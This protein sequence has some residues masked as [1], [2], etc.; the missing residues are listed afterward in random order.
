MS[1][2]ESFPSWVY[3]F[4]IIP[5][6]YLFKRHFNY[7]KTVDQQQIRLNNHEKKIEKMCR[8]SDDLTK[9]VH[10]MIGTLKEHLR[11]NSL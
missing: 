2:A 10:E 3:T 7:T 11:K 6:A 4:F 9:E 8:S 5:L 1:D